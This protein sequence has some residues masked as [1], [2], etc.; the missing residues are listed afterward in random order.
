QGEGFYVYMTYYDHENKSWSPSYYVGETQLTNDDHGAPAMW[1]DNEGYI[2]VIYGAH[3]NPLMHA[4]SVLPE[5]I[6]SFRMMPQLDT[7]LSTYPNV[8]YDAQDNIVHL[9]YR[10]FPG[11]GISYL[12]YIYSLD[13]GWT[14]SSPRVLVSSTFGN[15]I[16]KCVGGLDNLDNKKIHFSW[17]LYNNSDPYGQVYINVYYGFF[18]LNTNL[19]YNVTGHSQGSTV[20][21]NEWPNM[22]ALNTGGSHVTGPNLKVPTDSSNPYLV[23]NVVSH[24]GT[25]A[26]TSTMVYWTGSEWS[27]MNNIST[28]TTNG[29]SD[30][31]I[32]SP[33][34]ISAFVTTG[35]DI[36]H[37]TWDGNEWSFAEYC[38]KSS[39][40]NGNYLSWA[41]V[42]V[43][44]K[45]T[46]SNDP[47]IQVVFTEYI[48]GGGKHTKG[49]AW[50]VNG[51]VQRHDII[52]GRFWVKGPGNLSE[53]D[54]S[55]YIYY[56]RASEIS[57][58]KKF[59]VSPY[60]SPTHGAW[61]SVESLSVLDTSIYSITHFSE[62]S[63]NDV[64]LYPDSDTTGLG[65]SES[66]TGVSDW[67]S[68]GNTPTTNG[69]VCTTTVPG[70]SS[71][72]YL[73]SNSAHLSPGY[74][75]VELRYR[76]NVAGTSYFRLN[77]YE[78]DNAEGSSTLI[79]DATYPS[80]SWRTFRAGFFVSHNI[81]SISISCIATSTTT[82]FQFD[83]LRI[84]KET[85]WQ[86]DGSTAFGI[87]ASG[88]GSVSTDG[89]Y[90]LLTSDSDGSVFDFPVDPT[91]TAAVMSAIT[92]PFLSIKFHPGDANDIY[93]LQS[94]DG[95]GYATL[96]NYKNAV[97]GHYF[98]R[99]V[100]TTIASIRL[101]VKSLQ[102]IRIDF[103][104][105]YSIAN[106]SITYFGGHPDAYLYVDSDGSLVSSE[107][108]V[109]WIELNYEL[110]IS[111]N[112]E[113]Y[114]WAQIEQSNF[115]HF[116]LDVAYYVASWSL[117]NEELLYKLPT[118]TMSGFKIRLSNAGKI[119]S[120]KF[121]NLPLGPGTAPTNEQAPT[122]SNPDDLS[123]LYA[124]T[125]DYQITTYISDS[126]GYEDIAYMDLTLVS[127][128]H[129]T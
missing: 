20:T 114:Q 85:G 91:S 21:Q 32:Y 35:S 23:F 26:R 50:G 13:N 89:D 27:G 120:I 93:T 63:P 68:T 98:V 34:N 96:V 31:I 11:G 2:H 118:G 43:G 72:D 58:S 113:Q 127:N 121:G 64:L 44:H 108:F 51:I 33:S 15:T 102:T 24:R 80:T 16:Y 12:E 105:L 18:N 47:E 71:Y 99:D 69:D 106:F 10:R 110:P 65:F 112:T 59:T 119:N 54:Q 86:H 4:K 36:T 46:G 75:Y 111:I 5:R 52:G 67:T 14:W 48:T 3:N 6:D 126:D 8:A 76:A 66:F 84:S 128:D 95:S 19:V 77:G 87:T 109:N 123:Y 7:G 92:Y 129:V 30:I 97:D 39:D 81:E 55:I 9:W 1:I 88:G 25:G 22:M 115:S 17:A 122:I 117:W 104:K 57:L 124:R 116:N 100:D 38:Y 29:A 107:D 56:G 125:R 53:G 40:S 74:Y 45:W 42:P 78:Q 28:T 90:V 60:P 37:W 83:Y 49:Y 61:S 82:N 62:T 79:M 101:I 94:F 103:L 70:D 41:T 73:T